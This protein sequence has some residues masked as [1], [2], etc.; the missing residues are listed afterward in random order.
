[1][2]MDESLAFWG[3][4]EVVGPAGETV[5]QAPLFEEGLYIA[6]AS[7][8]DVRRE[9]VALPLLRDERLELQIRELRRIVGERAGIAPD[10]EGSLEE[11]A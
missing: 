2:G 3:G 1:V 5:F 10:A 9:R 11:R 8:A 7:L 6:E 4:S